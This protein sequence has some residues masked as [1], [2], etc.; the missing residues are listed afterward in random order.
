MIRHNLRAGLFAPVE[1]LLLEEDHD[2]SS[3]TYVK[4]SSLTVIDNLPLG[5]A[6]LALDD[7]LAALGVKV[8]TSKVGSSE[9]AETKHHSGRERTPIRL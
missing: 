3:P 1:L 5:A 2:R 8:A 6:A 7:K 9:S 4:P